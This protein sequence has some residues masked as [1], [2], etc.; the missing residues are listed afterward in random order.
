MTGE[1]S[2]APPLRQAEETIKNFTLVRAPTGN[3]LCVSPGGGSI[4]PG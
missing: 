1:D 2:C 4:L 3:D